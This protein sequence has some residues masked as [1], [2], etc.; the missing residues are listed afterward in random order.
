IVRSPKSFNSQTGVPLSVM[1][2][3]SEH[4]LGLFE[5]GISKPG[6]MERLARIIAPDIGIFTNIGEAHQEGFPDME[7]KLRE[8][9]LLFKDCKLLV[10]SVDN[11]L[12]AEQ[13]AAAFPDGVGPRLLGWS[14]YG[15]PADLRVLNY[16]F[17]Y[18]KTKISVAYDEPSSHESHFIE[19]EI[20]FTD[21]ASIENATHCLACILDWQSEL[22][23]GT[24]WQSVLQRFARL[25]PVAMRLELKEGINGCT[26]INDSYNSDLTSLAIALNFLQQQGKKLR[27]TLILSDILQSGQT[28]A[29][30][31]GTVAGLLVEKR[32]DRLIG[33][34]KKV[35]HVR[36]YLPPSF[37][38]KFYP[39]TQ[40]FF[41]DFSELVFRDEAILL[42]GARQFEFERIA[43][44]L[45]IKFHKTVLE[46][47]LS[48]LLNNLRVYQSQLGPGT[49]MMVMVKAGAYGSGSAEVAKLLEFQNVDYLGVAYA[50][51]GVELRKA[52]IQL[53]ILVMNPEEATFEAL[54]R[55]RLEPEIYS[56]SLLRNFYAFLENHFAQQNTPNGQSIHPLGGTGNPPQTGKQ[57]AINIH[58]KFDTGMHRLGF[59]EAD[60]EP[61]LE[62][63][64]KESESR[65]TVLVKT[66]FSH[67]AASEA[68]QHDD[69]TR[70]Q[71]AR[72]QKMY[73]HLV[74]GLG[75]SPMR[76]ILNSGGI[77]RFAEQQMEMV[78]LGIGLY[79]VD[80]SGLLQD[81]LQTV[82]TLKATISQIKNVAMG[83]TVGYG[84][85]GKAERPM[86]IATISLGYADGLLRRAG[87]GRFSVLVEG[88]RAPLIGN[89][90]MDMTMVD[91]TDI[92]EATEG[93]PVV[94]FGKDLPVQELAT[95]LGTIPYEIFT[96]ISERV[97][98]VYVQE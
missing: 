94:V 62:L 30:L 45:A 57:A 68:P 93:G 6:E 79:G 7:T 37:D 18:G 66:V 72:F 58:V 12:V 27:R 33:I 89:V 60:I 35:E 4:T 32:I 50:D 87:N 14:A 77:V 64:L 76:H 97:K 34:G 11:E 78:R 23:Q 65:P 3:T 13:I 69:F 36:K 51:E 20:P 84:R 39:T 46:V 61:L 8:K 29:Q 48:A 71:F 53:P 54:V 56:L 59:E 44:R 17:S 82:N 70:Q 16:L 19:I 86:R 92:P 28:V 47:N 22:R 31:Y 75:Y 24:D 52:G 80:S 67:L 85:L 88:K 90:C 63:L 43:N 10:Y 96:T 21:T 9:L 5:A 1:Q 74:G 2:L 26:V 15:K 25:E 98:R 91:V 55:Y 38:A 49:K 42:K 83:E 40:A 81:R 95:C 41:D 73:E